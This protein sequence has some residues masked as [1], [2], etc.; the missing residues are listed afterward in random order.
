MSTADRSNI[1]FSKARASVVAAGL[2]N[3]SPL[4]NILSPPMSPY[5]DAELP[6][7][8]SSIKLQ[9][10]QRQ[11][12]K[13]STTTTT[14]PPSTITTT[15]TES[16]LKKLHEPKKQALRAQFADYR[17]EKFSA[18]ASLVS[19]CWSELKSN[20]NSYLA[21]ERSFHS[22]YSRHRPSS[23]NYTVTAH[24]IRK[25]KPR[26]RRA[27]IIRQL[28]PRQ[29]VRNVVNS[30]LAAAAAASNVNH[31][32]SSSN[33]SNVRTS[34]PLSTAASP[35]PASTP[36]KPRTQTSSN[37][38]HDMNPD[39]LQDFSPSVST[40]PAGKTLRAEWKGAPMDLSQDPN[41]HL[42]H[43]AEVQLAA[44]LRLPADIYIDSKKR[45]FAEKVYR[46]RQGLPFRRTDSQ[47]A[48]RIDVN[49]ASRLFTAYEKV[50]WLDDIL[51]EKF[52]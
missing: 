22:L 2:S 33:S 48:C 17:L 13:S 15:P 10:A 41:L 5:P 30:S 43:P 35:T 28:T 36:R 25:P 52:M 9:L 19:C 12:A 16:F 44:V 1:L 29:S 18:D 3:S 4:L 50:G 23:A 27:D 51:F 39:Q 49:K 31:T 11:P 21:R 42:L 26:Q 46:L 38:V 32:T 47:K 14:S 45:L 8:P 7:S 34:T 24:A 40:L 6:E 37:K 20:P